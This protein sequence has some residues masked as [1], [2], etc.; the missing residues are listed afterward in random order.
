M[1]P[2]VTGALI[3]VALVCVV[4]VGLVV[5]L[6]RDQGRERRE[7]AGE[8][9]SLVDRA[10]AGSVGEVIALDRAARP[11]RDGPVEPPKLVEGLS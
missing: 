2:A 8:R 5:W 1:V 11:K 4:L 9:R 7:W 3:A 6:V 10:I